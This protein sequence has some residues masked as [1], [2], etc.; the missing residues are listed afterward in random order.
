MSM[1]DPSV[2]LQLRCFQRWDKGRDTPF[3]GTQRLEGWGRCWRVCFH[4]HARGL[5]ALAA[6]D[7]GQGARLRRK[8]GTLAC[9]EALEYWPMGWAAE[10]GGR[11]RLGPSPHVVGRAARS[12]GCVCSVA[13]LT[14]NSPP[15]FLHEV[16]VFWGDGPE[17]NLTSWVP[18]RLRCRHFFWSRRVWFESA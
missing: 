6:A 5:Q 8:A 15:F 3:S 12:A 1:S 4:L 17:E 14:A 9:L 11:G 18:G 2:T 13:P 16:I 7:S 10:T